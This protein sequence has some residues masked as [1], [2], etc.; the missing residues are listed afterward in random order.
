MSGFPLREIRSY[1]RRERP[2]GGAALAARERLWGR[3]AVPENDW[4]R[5]GAGPRDVVLDIGFG[6][7]E[8]LLTQAAGDAARDYVGVEVYRAGLVKVLRGVEQA[9]LTNV[10]VVEADAHDLLRKIGDRRVS[11]VQVFF[12]DPWPKTRHHKRRL[13]QGPFL[14]EVARILRPGGMLHLATDWAPYADAMQDAVASVPSLVFHEDG[15]AERP[16]TR[17]ERRGLK[18]GQ[19]ARDLRFLRA[20]DAGAPNEP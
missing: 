5:L 20:V 10:R 19:P 7:G 18:L 11:A 4:H 3:L 6:D 17:F 1:A 2:L 16:W 12:P 14:A 13:V 15:R 9:G 8:S